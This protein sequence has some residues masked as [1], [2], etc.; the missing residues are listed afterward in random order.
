MDGRWGL[1]YPIWGIS[2][3]MALWSLQL[4]LVGAVVVGGSWDVSSRMRISQWFKGELVWMKIG[5][6]GSPKCARDVSVIKS[7]S[8]LSNELFCGEGVVCRS[9][10]RRTGVLE[11]S[12][13]SR[14][15]SHC[16]VS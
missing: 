9:P 11:C 5:M 7:A 10:P 6:C 8:G 4:V 15:W 2:A 12:I 13:V 14:L 16:R 1:R 3:H